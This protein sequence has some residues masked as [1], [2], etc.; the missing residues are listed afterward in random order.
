MRG[1]INSVHQ[2]S[3]SLFPENFKHVKTMCEPNVVFLSIVPASMNACPA[4]CCI[5][6]RGFVSG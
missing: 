5:K 3:A 1:L 6:H 2:I 4:R